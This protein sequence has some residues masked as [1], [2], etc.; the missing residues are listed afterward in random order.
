MEKEYTHQTFEQFLC[1]MSSSGQKEYELI[2]PAQMIEDYC[3]EKNYSCYQFAHNLEGDIYMRAKIDRITLEFL[4]RKS[5]KK[6]HQNDA[7]ILQIRN[8]GQILYC[9]PDISKGTIF[10][11]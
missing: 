11:I 6:Q 7:V 4:T 10:I 2:F 1:S 8:N 9:K 5:L 3:K